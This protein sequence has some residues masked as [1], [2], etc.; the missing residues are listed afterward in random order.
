MISPKIVE[1]F[2]LPCLSNL[3][4]RDVTE[5]A[6]WSS[7]S[8]SNCSPKL[9]KGEVRKW[10]LE[11]STDHLFYSA[12]EADNPTLRMSKENE[13]RL[14][15]AIIVDY[16]CYSLSDD[17]LQAA[18]DDAPPAIA[19]AFV[20]RSHSRGVHAI[21]MLEES[22]WVMSPDL[23]KRVLDWFKK[24]LRLE[25]LLPGM[26]VKVYHDAM[27]YHHAGRD[28]QQCNGMLINRATIS[29]ALMECGERASFKGM[30]V[31]VPLEIVAAEVESRWPGRWQGE[32]VDG[33]RGC[34]FWE[35]GADALSV[36]VRP[37]G[38]TCYTGDFQFRNWSSI[39]G[40]G[41]V[42]QY[43]DDKIGGAADSAWF[44]GRD[45]WSFYD[46]T[47]SWQPVAREDLA[48]K[49][50]VEFGLSAVVGKGESASDVDRAIHHI[51]T[52]NRVTSAAPF[53]HRKPGII[54]LNGRRHLNTTTIEVCQPATGDCDVED[55][56]WIANFLELSFTET[57]NDS[58]QDQLLMPFAGE[59]QE[60]MWRFLAWLKRAYL[61]GLE[62]RPVQGHVLILA[63]EPGCGK[64]LLADVLIGGVMGDKKDASN[65]LLGETKFSKMLYHSPCWTVNDAA[66]ATDSSRKAR[67]NSLVK[68][69]AANRDFEMEAKFRDAVDVAW[70]GRLVITCNVDP[71]S[72]QVMPTMD[73]SMS[74]K[75]LALRVYG[76]NGEASTTAKQFGVWNGR[77]P[78]EN[79]RHELPAFLNWL[80]WWTPPEWIETDPR[81][82]YKSFCHPTLKEHADSVNYFAPFAEI[83]E[84]YL[85]HYFA[86]NKQKDE[87]K[88]TATNLL[89]EICDEFSPVKSVARE[90]NSRNIGKNLSNL[91][92]KSDGRCTK[93]I[94][95]GKSIYHF[96]REKWS[97]DES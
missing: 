7:P 95:M 9:K 84:T 81:F 85:G 33:A 42:E 72:I 61:G 67:Y 69:V 68:K 6:P 89:A 36:I 65:F 74:D 37:E 55:F 35:E 25:S 48:R 75:L 12:Y 13:A 63:G 53:M 58:G 16:E 30:G 43:L 88:G 79:V 62:Y 57:V 19:P 8:S 23:R 1:A 29:R 5:R 2:T 86:A 71:E 4:S 87:W 90:Y 60:Q 56:P 14:L 77:N 31:A 41:F 96:D 18:L 27:I 51:A 40:S 38:V 73:S 94:T 44:D 47:K 3:C 10:Q 92:A 97:K 82:G 78:D 66:A 32:F 28:W 49:L 70:Q 20:S 83:M 26:D 50:K 52:T 54:F 24:K 80:L 45:F 39:F 17:T 15:R 64:T 34:R 46:T 91:V 11:P 93:S 21:W 59:P 76:D 22:V